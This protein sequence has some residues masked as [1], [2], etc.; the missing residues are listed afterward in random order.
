MDKVAELPDGRVLYYAGERFTDPGY[1]L[2]YPEGEGGTMHKVALT[3]IDPGA[4][5][6]AVFEVFPSEDGFRWRLKSGNGEVVAQS[7]GYTTKEHAREGAVAVW[8]IAGKA[9]IDTTAE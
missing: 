4:Q 9:R 3:A 5:H 7:E 1:Y 2:G 8:R 6:D